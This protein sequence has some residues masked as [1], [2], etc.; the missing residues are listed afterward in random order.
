[1]R[2]YYDHGG[3]TIYHG[4]SRQ[5]L[6]M[7]R[8]DRLITDPVWPNADRR[9]AGSDDPLALLTEV[10]SVAD[11]RTV[12]I[13]LGRCSDPRILAAVPTRWPF[14]CISWLEY[15]VP[16]YTGRVLNTGDVAYTFG[17]AVTSAAGRR[18]VPGRIVST[19]GESERGHGRNRS[20]ASYEATQ[21]RLP[22]PAPR[23]L[24]HL[25]WL[26][27]WF[28][29]EADTVVDPFVGSGTTLIAAKALG[30]RAIGIEI[31][32][33]YCEIAAQRLSQETLGI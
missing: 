15:A 29:D 20:Q 11:V 13:Q 18:V 12:V 8:A 1:M 32:E 25:A 17:E 4:D 6:P 14:M 27:N 22:H 2:P 23:H 9:L 24:R 5:I 28:S 16:S 3:I 19:R 26:I 33:R 7:L 31:E 21:D 10:L 30:R